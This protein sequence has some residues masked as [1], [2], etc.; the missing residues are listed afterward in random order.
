[1]ETNIY[2]KVTRNEFII[3][4]LNKVTEKVKLRKN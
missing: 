3:A 4:D 2:E 1:M